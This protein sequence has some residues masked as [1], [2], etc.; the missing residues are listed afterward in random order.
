MNLSLICLYFN[1]NYL[2]SVFLQWTS[3]PYTSSGKAGLSNKSNLPA[4]PI[5][6]EG[7][8]AEWDENT[9]P[10]TKTSLLLGFSFYRFHHNSYKVWSVEVWT[11]RCTPDASSENA[12]GAVRQRWQ[13]IHHRFWGSSD[14][15]QSST[16]TRLSWVAGRCTKRKPELESKFSFN[17]QFSFSFWETPSCYPEEFSSDLVLL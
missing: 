6:C 9:T 13:P 14:P 7:S 12:R 2:V 4:I 11:L 5:S 8:Y 1:W 3:H 15:G 16:A 17:K 10:F